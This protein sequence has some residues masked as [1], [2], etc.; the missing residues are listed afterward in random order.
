MATKTISVKITLTP[1][2]EILLREIAKEG[3]GGWDNTGDEDDDLQ[4][5]CEQQVVDSVLGE[6]FYITKLGEQYLKQNKK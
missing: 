4:A 6:Q 1:S 3:A 5:L 2:Q